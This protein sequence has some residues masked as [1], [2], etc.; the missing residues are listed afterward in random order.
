M[1]KRIACD[2]KGTLE[3]PKKKQVIKI[4]DLFSKAGYAVTVW[5]NLYSYA[6]DAVKDN[7]LKAEAMSKRMKMDLGY[8]ETQYFDFAIEDDSRQEYLAAKKFIWVHDIPDDMEQIEGF[9]K[10]LLSETKEK[11]EI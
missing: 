3:G 9:V 2:V 4:L 7:N 6:V 1:D 10:G 8:D 5:S 11:S